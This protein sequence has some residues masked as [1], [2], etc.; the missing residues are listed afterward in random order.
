MF[1][2]VF[3]MYEISGIPCSDGARNGRCADEDFFSFTA[4]FIISSPINSF[5][6]VWMNKMKQQTG[7]ETPDDFPVWIEIWENRRDLRPIETFT[8]HRQIGYYMKQLMNTHTHTH[9]H[10]PTRT[11]TNTRTHAHTHTLTHT[12]T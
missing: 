7:R 1:I 6:F 11:S 3:F 2:F 4:Y 12:N 8:G 5:F 10:T 9:T